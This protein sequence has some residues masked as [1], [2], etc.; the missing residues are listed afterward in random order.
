MSLRIDIIF[1]K[2]LEEKHQEIMREHC[3]YLSKTTL[4]NF[5]SLSTQSRF[6]FQQIEEKY[7]HYDFNQIALGDSFSLVKRNKQLS[8]FPCFV[9]L[10]AISKVHK[11]NLVLAQLLQ[12]RVVDASYALTVLGGYEGF[13]KRAMDA[14]RLLFTSKNYEGLVKN[15]P[16]NAQFSAKYFKDLSLRTRPV[17]QHLMTLYYFFDKHAQATGPYKKHIRNRI[18]KPK[19]GEAKPEYKRIKSNI[20]L[21]DDETKYTETIVTLTDKNDNNVEHLETVADEKSAKRYFEFTLIAPPDVK[22][23][24]RLQAQLASRVAMAIQRREKQLTTEFRQLTHHEVSLL[25]REC[26]SKF[27]NQVEYGYLLLSLFLG[28]KFED[29]ARES[30]KLGVSK[31]A[32]PFNGRPVFRHKPELPEHIVASESEKFLNRPTGEVLLILPPWL[33][34][35]VGQFKSSVVIKDD[36]TKSTSLIIKRINKEY[37]TRL[38]LARI[39]NY[40]S[41]FFNQHGADAAEIAFLCG[42]LALQEPGCSYYQLPAQHLIDLHHRYV[43]QLCEGND[44][45]VNVLDKQTSLTVGSRL[46]IKEEWLYKIFDVLYAKLRELSCKGYKVLEQFHNCFTLY[47]LLVLNISTGHRPVRHPYHSVNC[48]DLNAGTVYISDKE[49][50]SSQSARVLKLPELAQTQFKYYLEHLEFIRPYLLNVSPENAEAI[51]GALFGTSPL[52]TMLEDNKLIAV[53]PG[54]LSKYF[55]EFLPLPLNW[56]RHFMRSWLRSREVEPHLVDAWMG[57]VGQGGEAFSRYSGIS[58]YDLTLV[59]NEINTLLSDDLNFKNIASFGVVND[60]SH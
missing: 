49:V 26:T 47:T 52:F 1:D 30:G 55:D 7:S 22:S 59:A 6:A 11:S 38:S 16:D 31:T 4:Q 48:F 13:I 39:C 53:T 32:S 34:D 45:C 51:D 54:V 56:N 18:S 24:S 25:M 33:S 10:C 46:Q 8:I 42:K 58:M 37:K 3:A 41:Y 23:S 44:Y 29:L 5:D 57:H 12:Y 21:D 60:S 19:M 43:S 50:R 20:E 15:L 9:F 17:N 35:V 2:G 40:M 28:R 36:I 14:V 27:K